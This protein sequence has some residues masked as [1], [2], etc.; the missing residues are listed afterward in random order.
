[1]SKSSDASRMSNQ[2]VSRLTGATAGIIRKYN[3][4]REQAPCVNT[5]RECVKENRP[6]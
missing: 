3:Q 5:E 6:Q 2:K 4:H 1:M